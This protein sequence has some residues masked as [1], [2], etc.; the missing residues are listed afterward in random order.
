M[1]YPIAQRKGSDVLLNSRSVAHAA[2]IGENV[3]RHEL[4][5]SLVVG[6]QHQR[7]S[8]W[9]RCCVGRRRNEDS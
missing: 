5:R 9:A 7:R 6:R 4:N 8:L 3:T 1:N 2:L